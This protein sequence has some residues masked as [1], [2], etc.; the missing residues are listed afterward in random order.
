MPINQL[1]D[2]CRTNYN[3]TSRC[4]NCVHTCSNSCTTC[5]EGIHM[6]QSNLRQYDCANMIYCYVCNYVNKYASEIYYAFNR[7]VSHPSTR[8]SEYHILSIGCGDCADLF[9]VNQFL[10]NNGRMSSISYTGIDIN[11]RWSPIHQQI[12]TIFPTISMN[13][14]YQDA[15]TYIDSLSLDVLPYNIVVLEYVLNEIRKYTPG[16]INSF[17]NCLSHRIIDKL[18]PESLV[19]INDINHYMVRNYYSRIKTEAQIN[20]VVSEVYLRFNTPT[21]HTDGGLPLLQ[22]RL[23]FSTT[24]DSRFVEKSPC[25]SSIYILIKQ[26]NKV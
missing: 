1:R 4:G 20:N 23:M 18:P 25:S 3:R 12:E 24:P 14:E 11:N 17:I 16:I 13:F 10:Q 5:L 2:F 9:G 21:I 22:D 6:N 26:S 7:L 15:F 19:V 8:K